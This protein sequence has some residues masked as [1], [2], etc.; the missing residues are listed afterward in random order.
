MVTWKIHN[1]ILLSYY[2]LNIPHIIYYRDY[3]PAA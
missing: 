2:N 3:H 1:K